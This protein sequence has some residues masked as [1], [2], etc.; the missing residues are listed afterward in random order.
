MPM[1]EIDSF[2]KF[3]KVDKSYDGEILV[4]KGLDLNIPKGEFFNYARTIWFGQNHRFN[5]VG[6]L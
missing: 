2:V 5:D 6:R 4:V 1:S 3:E